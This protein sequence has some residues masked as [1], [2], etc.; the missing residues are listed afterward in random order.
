MPQD[1]VSGNQQ[2]FIAIVTPN[3][4]KKCAG[5]LNRF[6]SPETVRPYV[7][8]QQELHF[9]PSIK[10]RKMVE[11]VVCPCYLFVQCTER[12]RKAIKSDKRCTFIL[13]FMK[14]RGRKDEFGNTLFAVIPDYQMDIFRKMV[15]SNQEVTIENLPLTA[16]TRVR[17]IEG[18]LYGA[19]GYL[20]KDAKGH[21]R[22]SICIDNIGYATIEIDASKVEV[23]PAEES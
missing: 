14:D 18:D 7:P 3:T 4:E 2:W 10:K 19:E 21:T 23:I 6:F 11:R 8:V 9:W 13:H 20:T 15:E 5:Y 17:I 22:I 12:V 1:M 16:G